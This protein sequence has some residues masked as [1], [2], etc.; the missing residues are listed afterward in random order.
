M[1][2]SVRWHPESASTFSGDV[3]LLYFFTVFISVVFTALIFF[4]VVFLAVRYRR[5]RAADVGVPI[6]GSNLLE[7]GWTV[8]P[9]IIML[10]LFAWGTRVFFT[11]SRPPAHADE[12]FCV[13]KQW[14]WKFQHPDGHREINQLHVP[15]GRPIKI[16]MT[17]EDVL[18]DLYFPAFRTK[19]DVIP[20]RYTSIWFEATKTGTYHIFCA[21]YCGPQHS[22]MIGSVIV[23]DPH[24][25]EM[26]LAGGRAGATTPAQRGAELFTALACVTCHREDTAARGPSLAGIFGKPVQ[27]ADGRSVIADEAYL[28]ESILSPATRVVAGYQPLMPTFQGQVGEDDLIQLIAYIKTLQAPGGGAGAGGGAAP[29][30]AG[31]TTDGLP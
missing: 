14:M 9:L 17:S 30:R 24:E 28:R 20:G 12:Y 27:L 31:F 22:G 6:H 1:L 2:K 7:I 29:Q 11:L 25:Y 16:T 23:M 8:I 5:R 26:W 18:H 15:V 19:M 4:L 13:G 3:D 10:V 21:E